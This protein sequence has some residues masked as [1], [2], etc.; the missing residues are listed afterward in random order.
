MNAQPIPPAD[1][2]RALTEIHTRREQVVLNTLVPDWFWLAISLLMVGFVAAMETHRPLWIITGSVVYALGLAASIGPLLLHRRAQV[3]P[4]MIGVHG[5][6]AIGVLVVVLVGLGLGVALAAQA[7]G[8]TRPATVGVTV[9]SV[10]MAVGGP[11]LMR[12][13]RRLMSGRPIGDGPTDHGPA[14]GASIGGRR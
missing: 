8:A 10:G 13:L 2:A 3:H 6:L 9:E 7:F 11:L 14:N 5:G 1:A 12:Y 4:S